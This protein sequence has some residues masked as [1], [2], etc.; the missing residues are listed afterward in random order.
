M[1][2]KISSRSAK[3]PFPVSPQA[4]AP[5]AGSWIITPL[6]FKRER[7]A[8]TAGFSYMRAFMAGQTSLGAGQA[9]KVLDRR[10][11]PRPLAALPILLA[12]AG[13]DQQIRPLGQLDMVHGP[14]P[15]GIK[16]FRIDPLGS[17]GL[18]G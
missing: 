16:K 4:S 5:E 13:Q 2:S 17:Q 6:S 15:I 12:V 3:R 8:W 7:L 18:K 9:K 14:R 11:S 1:D 10:S